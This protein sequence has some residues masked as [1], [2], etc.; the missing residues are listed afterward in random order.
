[1]FEELIVHRKDWEAV[2]NYQPPKRKVGRPL[3]NPVIEQ[4]EF[5]FSD[6]LVNVMQS[7]YNTDLET[8]LQDHPYHAAK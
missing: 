2:E 6:P 4:G 3:K 5:I 1:M 8:I 7:W